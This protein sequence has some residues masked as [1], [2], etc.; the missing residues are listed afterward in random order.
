[1]VFPVQ[2]D[3]FAAPQLSGSNNRDDV[4]DNAPEAALV[5]KTEITELSPFSFQ[6]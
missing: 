3:L 5:A 6:G 4:I 1:M 2:T